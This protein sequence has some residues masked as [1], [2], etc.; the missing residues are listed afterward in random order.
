MDTSSGI[1]AFQYKEAFQALRLDIFHLHLLRA[2][3]YL[4]V[5]VIYRG[6]PEFNRKIYTA[7]VSHILL[8][9]NVRPS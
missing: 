4:F 9:G 5:P 3:K 7:P 1:A 8:L 6:L 2:R